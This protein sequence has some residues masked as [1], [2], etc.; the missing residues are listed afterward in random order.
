M[1]IQMATK[2]P[3]KIRN[4][5][6]AGHSTCGKSSLVESL[7]FTGG[8]IERKGSVDDGT[9]VCDYDDQ[10]RER[11]HS[12][13]LACASVETQETLL[14]FIDTPG[15]RDFIGQVYCA[16][17]GTDLMAIVICCDE[18]ICPNTR[19]V[20]EI[21]R[22]A[23]LPCFVVINRVDREH[24]DFDQV[25][26]SVQEQLDSRCLP[27][28]APNESGAG[29]SAV[30]D[31]LGSSDDLMESIIESNDELMES[32]LE[33]EEITPE[34]L[35]KQCVEAVSS[36]SIF[37]VYAVS[38]KTDVGINELLDGFVRY[39]PPASLDQGREHF[40]PA[41][42]E[43]TQPVSTS[44][45][46]PFS[47][48]VFRAVSDPFV[49]KL[50]YLRV[51]SGSISQG[52]SFLNPHT[53]KQEKVGKLIRF[54]GKEQETVDG[55]GA[56]EIGALIKVEGLKT[57]DFLTSDSKRSM[58]APK[59]P[60]PMS[61]KATSPKTKADEK[62]FA[63]SFVKL[64]EED[65]CLTSSRDARTGELVISGVSDLH[66]Q[67]LWERLKSRYGV[68]VST[69]P[70]KI[71]YLE[72]ISAKGDAQYR[73][74]KQ[75]GGSGEFAEV[76]LR[77][78]PTER[79]AG[80]EF[81]NSIFG[82]SISQSYVQSV[83]KG[84]TA[85]MKDGVIAGCEFVDIKVEVYDGKEHPVDSKDVAFQKAG[86]GAFKEAVNNARPVLLEPIVNLEVTFPSEYT[87]DIQ[88][89]ITRRRGRVQ[90]VDALGDFQTLK[91][92]V[93]L[94]EISDYAA[95]LGSVTGGQ[96]SYTIELANYETAPGNVQQK[97][98]A[99]YNAERNQE[100]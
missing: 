71:P 91:A 67:I 39:A 41:N 65:V 78:E 45:D 68:E 99:A 43:D 8:S 76:W 77:V 55:L 38:S 51:Y 17:A 37:P 36:R 75:S 44:P 60:R 24:A 90:G 73:H 50:T 69:K 83:E 40:D 72:T 35:A 10:E 58:T 98:V 89:D 29:F 32:Y 15:Y 54:Q 52:G 63:E 20:W 11:N 82:G 6:F 80:L 3:G 16:T 34:V 87:G 26:S 85:M 84:I 64:V 56:G 62:K 86:R 13:D 2:S 66:L 25:L 1:E 21:A 47:A 48:R 81:A 57:F 93:P 33:G 7:L 14:Q 79:G 59:I 23:N 97:V 88:G 5:A 30:E 74:K 46:A 12:I 4:I 95:S 61:G 28:T 19:K 94:A 18:G 9:S 31:N 42:E 100:D 53:G 49:G 70:P 22:D 96:G 92:L 27:M